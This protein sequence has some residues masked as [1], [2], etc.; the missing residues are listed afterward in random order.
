M[1]FIVAQT[2][3]R[4]RW[5]CQEQEPPLNP[6]GPEVRYVRNIST[7]RG[8]AIGF[9]YLCLEGWTDRSDWRAIYD[10]LTTRGRRPS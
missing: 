6:L 5:W 2:Y 4:Y 3:N 10:V 7:L 8:V 9:D 1:R